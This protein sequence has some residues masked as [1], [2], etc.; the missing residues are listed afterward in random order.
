MKTQMLYSLK[1]Q[2]M[3]LKGETFEDNDSNCLFY[4]V[5]NSIKW[6]MKCFSPDILLLSQFCPQSW[7]SISINSHRI[8]TGAKWSHVEHKVP[9]SWHARR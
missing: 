4:G 2:N 8:H 1:D 5:V 6:D 7:D 3:Y 9:W